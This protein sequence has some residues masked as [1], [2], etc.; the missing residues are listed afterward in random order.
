[1]LK[2]YNNDKQIQIGQILFLYVEFIV[3][4]MPKFYEICLVIFH[5]ITILIFNSI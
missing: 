1:M 3:M 2:F 5:I 4:F